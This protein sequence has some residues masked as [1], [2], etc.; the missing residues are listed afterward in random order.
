MANNIM[1]QISAL[2]IVPVIKIDKVE[3]ALPLAKALCEGG[4]P[5]AEVTFRTECAKE[6]IEVIT[7]ELPEMI[8]GAGTVLTVQQVN[9][10]IE[11]GAKFIVSPGLNPAIVKYCMQQ[12]IKVIPGCANPSDIECA[13]GLGLD[14]VKIFPAEAVGGLKMIKAMAAPYT[15]MTFMPTGGINEKNLNE[16]LSFDKII[17]CGGSWMV[18]QQ[19][20]EKQ[21]FSKITN[22]TEEAV[23]QMLGFELAHVGINGQ[24]DE[25]ARGIAKGFGK[26]FGETIKEGNNSI[27]AGTGIEVMKQPY[28]GTKGHIAYKTNYLKRAIKYLEQKGITFDESTAKYDDKG[29]MIAIY[30]EGEIGGFAIHLLQKK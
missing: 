8:V 26:I 17:A 4:L 2:G 11:A 1:E 18:D 20:I 14:V 7:K 5:V 15:K 25:Q 28:L 30:I 22:L 16:Y 13:I 19:H 23:R 21:D 3:D 29:N 27:F 24:G 9:D 6:A 10:A 12:G